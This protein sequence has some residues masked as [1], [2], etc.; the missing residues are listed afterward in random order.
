[1]SKYNIPEIWFFTNVIFLVR[2]L[3]HCLVFVETFSVLVAAF[4]VFD[5]VLCSSIGHTA[6]T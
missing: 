4:Y 3:L 5:D 6:V 2:S 1:M